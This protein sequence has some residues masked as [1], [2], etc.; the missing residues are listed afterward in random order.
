MKN[1]KKLS[2][3]FMLLT[4]ISTSFTS[5]IDN[6]VSPVV[7]AIYEAQAELLAAQA[8][9]QDAEAAL[10][11]A[12]ALVQESM[13][14]ERNANAIATLATSAANVKTW[15]EELRLL[16]AQNNEN[17]AIAEIALL[18]AQK[19]WE[20]KLIQLQADIDEAGAVEAA[21]YL[22]KY[23]AQMAVVNTANSDLLTK[24]GALTDAELLTAT[25]TVGT[26]DYSVSWEFLLE[27]LANDVADQEAIKAA[28]LAAKTAYETARDNPTTIDTQKAGLLA[29]MAAE[30]ETQ[31]GLAINKANAQVVKT[32]AQAAIDAAVDF[33]TPDGDNPDTS[34]VETAWDSPSEYATALRG[35]NTWKAAYT[36]DTTAVNTQTAEITRL[37][38]I[39]A[40]Y[41]GIETTLKAAVT[42]AENRIGSL[43][44]NNHASNHAPGFGL[45][46]DIR[47]A[48]STYNA[49]VAKLGVSY[50]PAL[51]PIASDVARTGTTKPWDQKWN[52]ELALAKHN[53]A[54]AAL[55]ATYNTAATNLANAQSANDPVAAAL[56]VSNA[57]QAV[58]DEQVLFDADQLTY[59]N[60]K[61]AFEA[62]PNG[63]VDSDMNDNFDLFS[64]GIH[65]DVAETPTDDPATDHTTT[66]MR[67]AT[68]A[69]IGTSG[70]YAPASFYSGK[71]QGGNDFTTA[72]ND[73]VT[74][75]LA[76][77]ADNLNIANAGAAQV[78]VSTGINLAAVLTSIS[79]FGNEEITHAFWV[80]VEGDDTTS[81]LVSLFNDA[82]NELGVEITDAYYTVAAGVRTYV[83][84][85]GTGTAS[86]DL[87]NAKK[88]LDKATHLQSL[89]ST[90]VGIAQTAY[91]AQ[92]LLFDEGLTTKLTLAGNVTSANSA[93]TAANIVVTNALNAANAFKAEL[94]SVEY[95]TTGIAG[96]GQVLR[97]TN[98]PN[99]VIS[100]NEHANDGVSVGD[101]MYEYVASAGWDSDTTAGVDS[102]TAYAELWNAQNALDIHQDTDLAGYNAQL[103][104]AQGALNDATLEAAEDLILLT[105]FTADLAAVQ[106]KYDA[107]LLTP[108]Y[109][110]LNV[111]KLEADQAVAAVDALIA[112]SEALYSETTPSSGPV[113][114][115]GSLWDVYQ[116]L[117][118][119]YPTIDF[120]TKIAG[121]ATKIANA[122]LEIEVLNER[123]QEGEFDLE[124]A[125][126]KIADL[127]KQIVIIEAKIAAAQM[128]ADEYYALMIAALS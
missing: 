48:D 118:A 100:W 116:V 52:A 90:A 102:L 87:W 11:N 3:A 75:S 91:D 60:A 80:E 106:A 47:V 6:E 121:E 86:A 2:V 44:L 13:A 69:E 74:A 109:A 9:V 103:V 58:S 36:T 68:W 101:E 43:A 22:T 56:A 128:L 126:D 7:E 46:E 28:A 51:A 59:D 98:S 62:N 38:G 93:I 14:A 83:A 57:T 27:M 79:Q 45:L 64:V 84:D 96:A 12:Q 77:G 18:D 76:N 37:Q 123:I 88:A 4:L 30:L 73:L 95:I 41:A 8:R 82:T 16:V 63:S 119:S 61:V 104:T 94:G 17:I 32:S 89:G 127:K 120:A 19:D 105:K 117:E 50:L 107:L 113:V 71:Y 10:R 108:E 1:L 33:M 72:K 99:L 122:E 114:K 35:V 26:T 55:T 65:S 53:A 25:Y 112:M 15:E 70:L 54:F 97:T 39:I 110:A 31:K 40:D 24:Q 85:N 5:C 78:T 23:T 125:N 21:S 81:T 67:V 92:K 20:L 34:I 49:E 42:A 66:Y 124:D 29:Q 115:A 111:A